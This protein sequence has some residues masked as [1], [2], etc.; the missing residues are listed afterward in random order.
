[1]IT[2]IRMKERNLYAT[3]QNITNIQNELKQ[4]EYNVN[5]NDIEYINFGCGL[6]YSQATAIEIVSNRTKRIALNSKN[7]IQ[8]K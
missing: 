6:R 4:Y 5:H 2:T 7:K 3:F 8:K 1:M